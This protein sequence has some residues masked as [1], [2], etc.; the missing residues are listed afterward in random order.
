VFCI[1]TSNEELDCSTLS[2]F[3]IISKNVPL[4]FGS[5]CRQILIK[6]SPILYYIFIWQCMYFKGKTT[7]WRL[8]LS[9]RW[10]T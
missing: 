1:F 8:E 10:W 2:G 6:S 9:L 7:T 5:H 3:L 4:F